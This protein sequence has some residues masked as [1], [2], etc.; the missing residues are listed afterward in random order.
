MAQGNATVTVTAYGPHSSRIAQSFAV[1]VTRA[2]RAPA[3]R[4]AIGNPTV[5]VGAVL[6]YSL[7]D[8]FDD[9][10]GDALTYTLDV[11]ASDAVASL[12]FD[13]SDPSLLLV[14]GVKQGH[15]TR[16]L[17]ATA[18]GKSV[19]QQLLITVPANR[20]PIVRQAFG[21]LALAIGG[22]PEILRIADYFSDPDGAVL[23]YL[24]QWEEGNPA[25]QYRQEFW[26]V[27]QKTGSNQ[28]SME[29]SVCIPTWH[30]GANSVYDSG[31]HTVRPAH[32]LGDDG[33]GDTKGHRDVAVGYDEHLGRST[34]SSNGRPPDEGCSSHRSPSR[35]LEVAPGHKR[36]CG[37]GRRGLREP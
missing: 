30:K 20:R 10:D 33:H 5:G 28:L 7:D 16:L 14:T 18:R 21:P 4:K 6:T 32:R 31:W 3:S 1:T 35:A 9:P 13:S 11:E 17:T 22:Q 15:V 37:L 12:A 8:Y 34:P 19:S 29:S 26:H 2:D 25:T 24:S 23:T 36:R 27:T